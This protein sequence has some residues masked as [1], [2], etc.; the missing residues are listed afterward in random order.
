M[1]DGAH[2]PLIRWHPQRRPKAAV[3]ALHGFND[4]SGAFEDLGPALNRSDIAVYAY[5]QR[6]FG[7]APGRGIWPGHDILSRDLAEV[8]RLVRAEHPTLPL[9]ALGESM[10][11]A[12]IMT[13]LTSD[14]RPAIDGAILSAPAVWSR[15]TMAPW[16]R[17]ALDIA[18]TIAPGVRLRP[19]GIQITPSDNIEMLRALGRDPRFI[20]ETR[21]DTLAGLVDLMSRAL[22]ASRSLRSPLLILYGKQD[23]LVPKIPTCM[24]LARLPGKAGTMAKRIGNGR[25]LWRAALYPN[26]YH[27]LFRDLSG[28]VVTNDIAAWLTDSSSRLPSGHE[29]QPDLATGNPFPG[30]C[31]DPP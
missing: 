7:G 11:G 20:R 27:M 23:E 17:R 13:A 12:V 1:R 3:I 10:G 24:M 29:R 22:E 30:F 9:Y 14:S 5:D 4:H 31:P 19:Q 6:G 16:Q 25:R 2:L 18:V 15:Q 8:V 28:S 26:G 21:I